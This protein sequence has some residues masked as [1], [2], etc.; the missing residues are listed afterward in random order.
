MRYADFT[1]KLPRDGFAVRASHQAFRWDGAL[2]A[3]HADAAWRHGRQLS[4]WGMRTLS[5]RRASGSVLS[6]NA[7]PARPAVGDSRYPVH[8][9]GAQ[10]ASGDRQ[11]SSSASTFDRS[12]RSKSPTLGS[13][14]FKSV[15]DRR[16]L[17]RCYKSI[18]FLPALPGLKQSSPCIA[19]AEKGT[20]ADESSSYH[21]FLLVP[22][23]SLDHGPDRARP[24]RIGSMS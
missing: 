19:E 6:R 15:A 5:G 11:S 20:V 23:A 13:P 18:S 21:P 16:D 10:P 9:R 3:H 14:E 4:S 8:S 1:R 22:Y 7:S 12:P 2:H 17:L 24:T